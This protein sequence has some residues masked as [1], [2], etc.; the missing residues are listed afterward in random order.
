M[1]DQFGRTIDY[2]RV[3]VTD[4]CNLR[5]Q[6]C[7]PD[8]VQAAEYND[9]LS[10]EEILRLC[11]IAAALGIVNFK[12]TG[13]EPLVREGCTDFIARLKAVPGVEQVTITTNGLLLADHADALYAAGIDGINISLDTL[14]DREYGRLTGFSGHAVETILRTLEQCVSWGIRLKINTVLLPQTFECLGDFA[15]LVRDMPV[16]VRFIELMPLG[17]GRALKGL[18]VSA[19]FERLRALWPDLHITDEKRGSGPAR[20]Y[21]VR[22][23]QG[24]IGFIDAVSNCFCG[25]CNRVRLTATGLLKP[26]LCYAQGEDLGALL[27]GGCDDEELSEVMR[28]CIENKPPRHYF[29]NLADMMERKSMN[30]IGG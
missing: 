27:R 15:L 25:G 9:V 18:P 16:D 3:S 6:Y 12:V 19:A 20:Y 23:F 21:A 14:C 28:D 13:G 17:Q 11:R 8:G 29:S 4:R 1:I 7:M 2:M 10:Y 22:G 30:Q 5:C 24:R 26:C